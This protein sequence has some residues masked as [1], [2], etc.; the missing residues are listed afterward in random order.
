MLA[1]SLL[2]VL[3]AAVSVQAAE[4]PDTIAVKKCRGHKKIFAAFDDGTAARKIKISSASYYQ[5]GSIAVQGCK[6]FKG[7]N[8]CRESIDIGLLVQLGYTGELPCSSLLY[9]NYSRMSEDGGAGEYWINSG[10]CSVTIAKN[11]PEKGRLKGTYRVEL[12]DGL[13]PGASAGVIVGCFSAK[14]QNL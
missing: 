7:T 2:V 4:I 13:S 11:D 5:A 10:N 8:Q 6:T 12:T 9:F 14:R 3:A 1:R